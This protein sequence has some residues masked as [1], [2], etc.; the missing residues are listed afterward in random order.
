MKSVLT[1]LIGLALLVAIAVPGRAGDEFNYEGERARLHEFLADKHVDVGDEYKK[2]LVFTLARKQYDRARELEPENKKA[3]KG[4][5]YK[6]KSGKW[7]PDELMPDKDGVSGQQYLEALKKP[8]EKRKEAYDK[9]AERCRK[10]VE[11]AQGAGDLRSAR[12]FAIDL[13]YY[14]PEDAAAHKLRGHEREGDNWVPGFAKKWRDEGHK[15]VD[16][17]SFGD[18]VEGEDEQ[19]T[20]I[21]AK[22]NRR[23]SEWLMART[24]HDNPRV[25]FLHRNGDATIKRALELLG[26][27]G[28][29]FGGHQYTILALQSGDEYDAMLEKVLK[30]EGDKLAFAKRLS[31]HGQS[32]PYGYFC[33]SN[34][35]A[36]ADDMLCN[37]VA[38][39]V[40][41]HAQSGS[42]DRA[43]WVDTGFGYL[44][45]SQ[46][47][48]TTMVQRYTLKEIGATT[49]DDEV[50][51]EFT[52][53]S[54]TPELLRE[55]A[56]YN[57]NFDR[58]IPLEQLVATETNDM[59]QAHAA[60]AFSF[61]EFIYDQ[62]AEQARK[63]LKRGG[64]KTAGERIKALEEDFGKPLAELE[65]A[66]REW[67]LANY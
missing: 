30:L 39:R 6:Q 57:V 26:K 16:A 43:P 62:H 8:G 15:I 54:G 40:L 53:K 50:I 7:V 17:A 56:L 51:P 64:A 29:P 32:K 66:W 42:S 13:L 31:G 33:W 20:A 49:A 55:V 11:K 4:L 63:W 22:F 45:T 38:L 10:L 67:V 41:A 52:K 48:G 44:V 47:L 35:D 2:A 18:E 24:T 28:A 58:D 27:D 23:Q 36:S 46:V 12:I 37:T 34:T 9:C 1:T 14:A 25:K 3:W 19:A 5:G 59:Q 65:T 60:K 61:M 21:G